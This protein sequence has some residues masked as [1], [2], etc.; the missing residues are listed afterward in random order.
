MKLLRRT[1]LSKST[2]NEDVMMVMFLNIQSQI[3]NALQ[4]RETL[5]LKAC[6]RYFLTNFIK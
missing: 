1:M 5:Q 4:K 2:L 3:R 6:V